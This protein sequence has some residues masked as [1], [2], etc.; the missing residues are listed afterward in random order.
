MDSTRA[1]LNGVVFEPEAV[2]QLLTL[3]G[4]NLFM[5]TSEVDKLAYVHWKR[6]NH[7]C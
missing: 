4:T 3:V 6:A 7:R 5:L 2:E 1:D